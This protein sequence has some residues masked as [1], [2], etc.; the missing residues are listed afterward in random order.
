MTGNLENPN[1]EPEIVSIF[2]VCCI[3]GAAA[4]PPS[5][6]WGPMAEFTMSRCQGVLKRQC[7]DC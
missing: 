3:H 2:Q 6:N 1:L 7:E 4:L 5:T